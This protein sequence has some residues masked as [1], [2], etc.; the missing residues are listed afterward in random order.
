MDALHE[1]Y[2]RVEFINERLQVI[3]NAFGIDYIADLGNIQLSSYN[4]YVASSDSW[5]DTH[6]FTFTDKGIQSQNDEESS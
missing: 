4:G 6:D 3:E 1:A 5:T 2:K